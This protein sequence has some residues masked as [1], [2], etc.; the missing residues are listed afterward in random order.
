MG[1]NH[2]SAV[3][4]STKMLFFFFVPYDDFILK[5]HLGRLW[6]LNVYFYHANIKKW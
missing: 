3:F 4:L 5:I 6:V 1:M 2:D